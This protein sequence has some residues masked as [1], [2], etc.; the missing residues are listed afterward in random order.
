MK[1]IVIFFGLAFLSVSGC[2]NFSPMP[3][4]SRFFTLTPLPQ[5]EQLHARSTD[6]TNGLFVGIAPIRFPGYLDREQIVTRAAQNRLAILENDRWAEP[7]EENFTRV[8][9][10][11][12]GILL[13]DAR[14]IRYPWQSSQRPT[15][16][17]EM[18]VLR[19][20]PS[21]RQEV[22]LLARWALIDLG[23]K[24]PFSSKESRIVR[25]TGT[26]SMEASVAGLSETLGDLSREI[27]DTILA[28][29]RPDDR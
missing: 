4:P 24:T 2:V 25:Q 12:L 22:E 5:T 10:Q 23:N 29:F 1:S 3:D 21:T 14:V 9:A 13:A 11:N 17:I 18:E 8:L 15:C 16:Q 20:E 19:F 28:R 27:A 26:K 6:K 7:L